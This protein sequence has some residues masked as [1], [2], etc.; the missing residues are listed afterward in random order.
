MTWSEVVKKEAK[1]LDDCSLGEVREVA[2]EYILTQKGTVSKSHY[3]LPRHLVKGFDG[4]K[5]WFNITQEQA[6]TE[7]KRQS[8]PT[9]EEYAKYKVPEATENEAWVPTVP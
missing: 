5:L 7:F 4:K 3:Y 6:E 2:A 1:G 8:P 9:P